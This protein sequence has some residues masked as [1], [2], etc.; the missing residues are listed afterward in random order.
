MKHQEHHGVNIKLFVYR[1]PDGNWKEIENL[2]ILGSYKSPDFYYLW[3]LI[4]RA[5]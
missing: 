4:T 1:R 5:K 2:D 3:Y